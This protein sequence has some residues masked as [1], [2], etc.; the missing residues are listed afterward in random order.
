VELERKQAAVNDEARVDQGQGDQTRSGRS[1]T[2]RRVRIE[3]HGLFRMEEPGRAPVCPALQFPGHWP[4]SFPFSSF[5]RLGTTATSPTRHSVQSPY[6]RQGVFRTRRVPG[7]GRSRRRS[8]PSPKSSTGSSTAARHVT[9]W[10]PRIARRR[11]WAPAS[12]HAPS[13]TH[14]SGSAPVTWCSSAWLRSGAAPTCPG[15][16]DRSSISSRP[17][18]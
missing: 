5:E 18:F 15:P 2:R 1:Q 13:S 8:T 4:C 6:I 14:R 3:R 9:R 11:R 16:L 10:H 7:N 17:V 12:E